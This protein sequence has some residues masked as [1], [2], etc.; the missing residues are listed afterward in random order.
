MAKQQLSSEQSKELWVWSRLKG[1]DVAKSLLGYQD[2]ITGIFSSG[3][4]SQD[5]KVSPLW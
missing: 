3:D 1:S 5:L 2:E 4:V